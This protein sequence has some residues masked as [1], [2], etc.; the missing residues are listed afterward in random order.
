MTPHPSAPMCAPNLSAASKQNRGCL[1][2]GSHLTAA[3]LSCFLCEWI[4]LPQETS[5]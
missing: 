5:C 2:S 3:A 1:G 4:S